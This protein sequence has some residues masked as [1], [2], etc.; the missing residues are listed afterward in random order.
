MFLFINLFFICLV[1]SEYRTKEITN[2]IEKQL[3]C[4][5]LDNVPTRKRW[6]QF[7]GT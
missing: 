2:V 5:D 6:A 4:Y 7:L 1:V 3:K